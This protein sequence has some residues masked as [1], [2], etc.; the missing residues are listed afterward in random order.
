MDW[1]TPAITLLKALIQTPSFSKKEEKTATLLGEFFK[2]LDIP[3][4]RKGNNI[5]V[6][7]PHWNPNNPTILLN[8]HHD[9]VKVVEG[10]HYDPFGAKIEAG[11][12]YGLGSNDAGGPL[13]ALIATF[14]HFYSLSNLPFNLVFAASAEEEISGAGGVQA[15]LSDLPPIRFAI[16]GEPTQMQMA[17]AEKGLMVIDAVAVG[18]AGHAARAEGKNAIYVAMEDIRWIQSYDFPKK[19]PLLGAVKM[20]VTQIQGGKQHNIVPDTCSYVID[21][22]TTEAYSN[23]AIFS[24]LQE[25]LKAQLKARSFRL[26]PSSINA[27][28]AFVAGG[29]A[30]GLTSFGSATLSDQALMPFPSLKIGPGDSTRSHTANEYIHLEEIQ[31]GI[32]T[33]IQLLSQYAN[34]LNPSLKIQIASA[35]EIMAKRNNA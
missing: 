1:S 32:R 18:I 22:R 8:S 31:N 16:V 15:I 27:N 23:E 10:W 6:L 20:S 26:Q 33:Y 13:V 34:S 4:Q 9:T 29:Q 7:H 12:L 35:D 17:I 28:H 21:V 14:L 24:F 3:F 5:W 2:N 11:K 25:Q 19:S 30:L